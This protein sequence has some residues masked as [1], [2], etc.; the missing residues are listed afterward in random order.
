[1]NFL[2]YKSNLLMDSVL[3]GLQKN[4][5]KIVLGRYSRSGL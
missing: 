5:N 2:N 4:W 3:T 1:M